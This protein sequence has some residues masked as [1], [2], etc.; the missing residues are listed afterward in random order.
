MAVQE[1]LHVR[2]SSFYSVARRAK[3]AGLGDRSVGRSAG[4]VDGAV[5]HRDRGGAGSGRLR[6]R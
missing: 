4:R 2:L 3:E 5:I 6:S 1:L